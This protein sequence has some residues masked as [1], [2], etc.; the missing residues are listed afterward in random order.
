LLN[1]L[2]YEEWPNLEMVISGHIHEAAGR[3]DHRG[4]AIYGVSYMNK[5]YDVDNP[6]KIW[7]I[8]L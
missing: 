2:S 1:Q 3:Y 6:Q 5:E 7:E 8:E 4:L